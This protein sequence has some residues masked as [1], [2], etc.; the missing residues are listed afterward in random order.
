MISN[1]FLIGV[2]VIIGVVHHKYLHPR[3]KALW[4]KVRVHLGV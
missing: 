4:A 3:L 2:G 1:L